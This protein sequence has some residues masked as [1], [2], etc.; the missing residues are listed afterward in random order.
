M[1]NSNNAYQRQRAL[2]KKRAS[3]PAFN[4]KYGAYIGGMKALPAPALDPAN[5]MEKDEG[6]YMPHHGHESE[7]SSTTKLRPVWDG[8]C[9]SKSKLSLN[10]CLMVGPTVQPESFN[11]FIHFGERKYALKCDLEKMFLKIVV[12]PDDRKYLKMLW[13]DVPFGPVE[14]LQFRV[15]P[16]GLACSPHLATRTVQQIAVDHQ[17]QFPT[18]SDAIANSFYVDDGLFCC[19]HE[20]EGSPVTFRIVEDFWISKHERPQ[21]GCK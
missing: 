3:N 7:S 11:I 12:H 18:T 8:S 6:S 14:H 10:D 19:R 17:E 1:F 2:D 5:P 16:F 21:V 20:G 13:S 15:L 9:K 4:D